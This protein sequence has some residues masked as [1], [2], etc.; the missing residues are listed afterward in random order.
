M[1]R[2]DLMI[3]KFHILRKA[4]SNTDV[5]AS[6]DLGMVDFIYKKLR[7]RKEKKLTEEEAK[8]LNALWKAYR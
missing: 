6:A 7:A 4:I 2:D 1:D 3:D 5:A 8:T